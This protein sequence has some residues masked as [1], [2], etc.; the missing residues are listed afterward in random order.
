MKQENTYS[1]KFKHFGRQVLEY[2]SNVDGS[3]G[4]DA[5]LVLGILLEETL[6][7]AAGELERDELAA[8]ATNRER[9]QAGFSLSSSSSFA[10]R[11]HG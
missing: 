10:C 11:N 5:H 4:A 6:D 3:L 7:T 8:M 9:K 1:C 2:G